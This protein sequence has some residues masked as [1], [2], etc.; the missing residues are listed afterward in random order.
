MKRPPIDRSQR[1]LSIRNLKV[2]IMSS[3]GCVLAFESA[4]FG[5]FQA[6]ASGRPTALSTYTESRPICQVKQ[7]L[8]R[9]VLFGESFF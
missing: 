6:P 1:V 3:T 4:I 8:A 2:T 5:E 9:L 7:R